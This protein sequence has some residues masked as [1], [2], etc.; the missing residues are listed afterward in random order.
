MSQHDE[1]SAGEETEDV[2]HIPREEDDTSSETEEE[3]DNDTEDDENEDDNANLSSEEPELNLP[4]EV[5]MNFDGS[6]APQF[7]FVTGLD[8]ES[9]N[10][11]SV[12]FFFSYLLFNISVSLSVCFGQ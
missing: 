6:E 7:N 9:C 12:D 5:P 8:M 3:D 4:S 11:C 2:V 10:F 1:T